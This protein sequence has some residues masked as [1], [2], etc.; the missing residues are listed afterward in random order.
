MIADGDAVCVAR[1]VGEHGLRPAKRPL[2]IDDPLGLAQRGEE[3]GECSFFGERGVVAEDAIQRW[4][5][6]EMPPP[7]TIMCTCG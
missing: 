1:Q 5:S 4:P 2:G 7:G 3:G 6:S